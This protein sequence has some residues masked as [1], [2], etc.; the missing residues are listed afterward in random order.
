MLSSK[1]DY[2]NSNLQAENIQKLYLTNE[3]QIDHFPQNKTSS[4]DF[5]HESPQSDSPTSQPLNVPLYAIPDKV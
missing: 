3:K 1:H 2:F 4:D 5:P